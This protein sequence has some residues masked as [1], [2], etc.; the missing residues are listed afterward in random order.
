V[1]R[2]AILLA[3]LAVGA[4]FAQDATAQTDVATQTV[5]LSVAQIVDIDIPANPG[6]LNISAGTFGSDNLTPVSDNSTSYSLLQ[7]VA[8]DFKI[9]AQIGADV[10]ANTT[11]VLN[12]QSAKGTSAGDVD[13]SSA[14]AAVDCVSGINF[15]ADNNQTI[16]YTYSATADAGVVAPTARVVTFTL[17]Q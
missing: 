17:T 11:L 7:N 15:G 4:F 13:I 14:A 9:T 3:V 6:P 8:N 5:T 12:L 10:P 16:T 2:F 1:K